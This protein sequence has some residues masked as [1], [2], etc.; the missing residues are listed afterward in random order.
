MAKTF[1]NFIA[2]EWVAPGDRRLLREP[3]SGRHDAT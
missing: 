1:K 3:E 2:G